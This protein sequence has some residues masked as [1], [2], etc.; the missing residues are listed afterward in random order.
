MIKLFYK[1]WTI[2]KIFDQLYILVFHYLFCEVTHLSRVY[3]EQTY[4]L[5]YRTDILFVHTLIGS[6]VAGINNEGFGKT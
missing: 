6:Y 4:E 5:W 1:L 2:S 3:Q